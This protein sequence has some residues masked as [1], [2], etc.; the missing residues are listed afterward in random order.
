MIPRFDLTIAPDRVVFTVVYRDPQHGFILMPE[1]YTSALRA[2]F[3]WRFH[4][5]LV[6]PWERAAT[7]IVPTTYLSFVRCSYGYSSDKAELVK[8]MQFVERYEDR[9]SKQIR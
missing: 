8:N 4:R 9:W 2:R 3:H 6:Q 7:Q 5:A 1:C